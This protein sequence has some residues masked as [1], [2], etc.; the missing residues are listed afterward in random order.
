FG[1]RG[2]LGVTLARAW[3]DNTL[4]WIAITGPSGVFDAPGNIGQAQIDTLNVNL[5]TP[6]ALIPGA[7]YAM[8]GGV[9]NSEVADPLTGQTR[10]LP[11]VPDA[12]VWREFRQE[13]PTHD[14]SWALSYSQQTPGYWIRHDVIGSWDGGPSVNAFFE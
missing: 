14:F 2:S 12:R 9:A 1:R 4:D 8:S 3:V 13:V 5:S 6:V 10:R 11:G 7:S